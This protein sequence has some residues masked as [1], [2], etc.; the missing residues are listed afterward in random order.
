VRVLTT[1]LCYPTPDSPDQ[2]IFIQRRAEALAARQGLDLSVVAPQPWFP[3]LRSCRP[4]QPHDRPLPAI[5]PHMISPPILGW[6]SDGLAYARVLRQIIASRRLAGDPPVD[7]LDAHFVYPEGVGAWLAG[8]GLGIPA[9]VTVRGKI[10]RLSRRTFRRLQIGAMLRGVDARIAVSRSLVHWIRDVA[11]SDLAVD[12]IPNGICPDVYRRVDQERAREALGWSP[13]A[14]YILAVGHLQ[15]LKGFDRL[16]A[17]MP[18]VWA[19]L[20]DVRLVL[21]GSRRGEWW[22]RRRV[23]RMIEQYGQTRQ[24]GIDAP[25]VQFIG[26]TPSASLN[27]MYNATDLMVNASRSEGWNNAIAEALAVGTPVVATDVG[28]NPEQIRSDELGIIVP[29]GD[30]EAL[31]RAIIAALTRTWSPARITSLGGAR[32]WAEVG[33]EVHAVFGRVL[34]A[35]RAASAPIHRMAVVPASPAGPPP[36]P[37]AE[38]AP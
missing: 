12:V 7:L 27:L 5:Y 3:L 35:R 29:D 23:L 37:T 4:V 20:G 10:V 24:N 15:H 13:R 8:R 21:A 19:A 31:G 9:V 2:G 11:G 6:A 17:V 26:P 33:E 30:G 28:G 38:V 16:L 36:A 22:F 1:T 25:R 32:T 18:A 34:A 14:R